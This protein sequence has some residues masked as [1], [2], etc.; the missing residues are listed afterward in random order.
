MPSAKCAFWALWCSDQLPADISGHPK[1]GD[2]M[3][4]LGLF[5]WELALFR[6]LGKFIRGSGLED[7]LVNSGVLSKDRLDKWLA[8]KMPVREIRP[9]YEALYIAL[10]HISREEYDTS[11]AAATVTF[12]KWRDDI[13]D[14]STMSSFLFAVMRAISLVFNF[15]DCIREVDLDRLAHMMQSSL[16]VFYAGDC[17][18]Y[19]KWGSLSVVYMLRWLKDAR[20]RKALQKSF[21]RNDESNCR[22]SV[23]LDQAMEVTIRDIAIQANTGM[24]HDRLQKIVLAHPCLQQLTNIVEEHLGLPQMSRTKLNSFTEPSDAANVKLHNNVRNVMRELKAAR[25]LTRNGN[26]FSRE[27]PLRC[28]YRNVAYAAADATDVFNLLNKPGEPHLMFVTILLSENPNDFVS[29]TTSTMKAPLFKN[30]FHSNQE[31]V[32][33]T[34]PEIDVGHSVDDVRRFEVACDAMENSMLTRDNV[35]AI[36]LRKFFNVP[37]CFAPHKELKTSAADCYMKVYEQTELS[38]SPNVNVP[39]NCCILLLETLLQQCTG[40]NFT[41]LFKSCE[42]VLIELKLRFTEVI[43]V[44]CISCSVL[45]NCVLPVVKVS[46]STIRKDSKIISSSAFRPVHE[47]AFFPTGG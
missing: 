29:Q 45:A 26:L 25:N 43:V 41:N 42:A 44:P 27:S 10:D 6:S 38:G 30:H 36:Q 14:T 19:L 7:A 37:P 47:A 34:L 46:Y 31:R 11:S 12:E 21:I 23:S 16:A 17:P 8:A 39:N 13:N 20:C 24:S 5:H 15:V 40:S 9:M 28:L 33:L 22:N 4:L 2:V 35:K 18:Q 3:V 32:D 1:F